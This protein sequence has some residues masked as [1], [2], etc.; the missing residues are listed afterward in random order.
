MKANLR[1]KLFR[2]EKSLLAIG[3]VLLLSF[4][5]CDVYLSFLAERK[6]SPK[7]TFY[8]EFENSAIALLGEYP[9]RPKSLVARIFQLVLLAFGVLIFGYI[10]SRVSSVFVAISLKKVKMGNYK[11]HI[12]ICNWNDDAPRI[13]EQL[14]KSQPNRDIVVISADSVD[15]NKKVFLSEDD[16]ERLYCE[17]RDPTL[18]ENLKA[19]GACDAKSV[20]ILSD[21]GTDDPDGKTAL[22]ALAIK[23]LEKNSDE[24][25]KD[26]GHVTE[27]DIHV[28]A[29][30]I[31]PS[32]ER[33]L[34]EAGADEVVCSKDYAAGIIAQSANFAKMSNI[35]KRL[36]TYTDETNEIYYV[37]KYPPG[38][39]GK[40]FTELQGAIGETQTARKSPTLLIGVKRPLA[41][42]KNKN[43]IFLNPRESE[44]GQLK[45]GDELIVM[46]YENIKII[47]K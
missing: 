31:D 29:E 13:I 25:T 5:W 8:D 21:P 28:I 47:E 10:V 15:L 12:I 46:S 40:S 42:T 38:F 11:D 45:N 1:N 22:I 14:M 18:H 32:R 19:L 33:H 17:H 44:L 39:I 43:E 4:F 24:K 37:K 36:L 35:Y 30:L 9:D 7:V 26:G 3:A 27:K 34:L 20:I 16:L 6:V 23:H 41:D 2:W